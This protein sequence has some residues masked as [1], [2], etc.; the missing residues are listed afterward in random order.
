MSE[1]KKQWPAI[2]RFDK[3]CLFVVLS[4]I[5]TG[6]LAVAHAQSDVASVSDEPASGASAAKARHHIGRRPKVIGSMPEIGKYLEIG[7]EKSFFKMPNSNGSDTRV[8]E[9]INVVICVHAT[10][11]RM[12]YRHL[13]NALGRAGFPAQAGHSTGYSAKIEGRTFNQL[14]AGE[15]L[16]YSNANFLTTNDHGRF[17]GPLWWPKDNCYYF[18]GAFSR[19]SP[20]PKDV[21]VHQN[22]EYFHAYD[23]FTKAR[24][25]LAASLQSRS[26]AKYEGKIPLNNAQVS[27]ALESPGDHD[28]M[29]VLLSL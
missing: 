6:I 1:S 4:L 3:N 2:M 21:I 14:P 17:F 27:N 5:T 13:D 26:G 25:N 19:E 18:I 9:P 15:G 24:D 11:P 29:A 20:Y 8:V 10:S 22:K 12:A 23:S 7:G 28:G 16:A